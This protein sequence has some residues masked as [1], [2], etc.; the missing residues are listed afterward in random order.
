MRQKEAQR[1]YR[2][3]RTTGPVVLVTKASADPEVEA[4]KGGDVIAIEE[5]TPKQHEALRAAR[6]GNGSASG[7]AAL[8]AA[9]SQDA[10]PLFAEAIGYVE[11]ALR[12]MAARQ[13]ALERM[14]LE[15][16]QEAGR[17]RF[18][19]MRHGEA[20]DV[21]DDARP[22]VSAYPLLASTCPAGMPLREHAQSILAGNLAWAEGFLKQQ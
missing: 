6:A 5:I 7:A 1:L 3:E 18:D 17:T 21:L 11:S 16:A 8:E 13:D 20:I 19:L 12:T 9:K 15:T 10:N 14:G 22:D 4:R 2:V